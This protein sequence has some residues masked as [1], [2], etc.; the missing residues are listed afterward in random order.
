MLLVFI[1]L[2]FACVCNVEDNGLEPAPQASSL[3]GTKQ[4]QQ[5]NQS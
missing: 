2:Y 3:C 4:Q 5:K 1:Y